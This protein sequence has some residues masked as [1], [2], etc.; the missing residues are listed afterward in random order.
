MVLFSRGDMEHAYRGCAYATDG[1]SKWLENAQVGHTT[2]TLAG[3]QMEGFVMSGYN[4]RVTK[5]QG[6]MYNIPIPSSSTVT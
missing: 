5:T 4:S 3:A 1:A 2:P 6:G